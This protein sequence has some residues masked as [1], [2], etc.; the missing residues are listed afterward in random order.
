M[1]IEWLLIAVIST[2]PFQVADR[3]PDPRREPATAIAACARLLE[4]KEYVGFVKTCF[5]P[6]ELQELSAKYGTEEAVAQE[7]EKSGGPAKLL[8]VLKAASTV[9]P[10]MNAAGTRADYRFEKP[11]AG[12]NRLSLVKIGELWFLRD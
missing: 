7:F 11:V 8:D 5:R 1:T 12:A 3:M 4:A 2:G 9:T 6:A 10:V